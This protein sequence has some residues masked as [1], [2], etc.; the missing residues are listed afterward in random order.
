ML[1]Y[2]WTRDSYLELIRGEDS[3]EAAGDE[4]CKWKGP[5]AHGGGAGESG[6]DGDGGVARSGITILHVHP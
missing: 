1:L 5:P 3:A 2:K 6:R 4:G